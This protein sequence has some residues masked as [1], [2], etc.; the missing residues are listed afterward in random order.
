MRSF[1]L[2]SAKLAGH[3]EVMAYFFSQREIQG[4][5]AV[6]VCASITMYAFR[7]LFCTR[8]THSQWAS[9]Q[10]YDVHAHKRIPQMCMLILINDIPDR[11]THVHHEN[12]SL[13]QSLVLMRPAIIALVSLNI[14]SM[15]K[16]MWE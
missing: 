4:V 14:L 3:A 10:Y 12:R 16:G 1:K 5:A 15:E 13:I 9:R 7:E 2:N 8:N 6:A 11:D